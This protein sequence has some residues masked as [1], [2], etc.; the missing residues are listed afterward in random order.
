M[1][2]RHAYHAGNFADVLKHAVLC[3]IVRY[4]QQKEA[5]LCLIDTHAGAGIYDLTGSQAQKTGEARNG[6]IFAAHC[7]LSTAHYSTN[8]NSTGW[9]M[10]PARCASPSSLRIAARPRSP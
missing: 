5:P 6:I 4:L 7:T 8:S 2:Y 1:N 9:G 3:W 10:M